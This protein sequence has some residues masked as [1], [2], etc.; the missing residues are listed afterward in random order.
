MNLPKIS[1]ITPSYNQGQYL[2]QTIL[3]VIGQMYPNLE[4]IIMDGGSTDNSVE[5][6]KKYEKHITYWVSKKDKGQAD[7]I[8]RGFER[9]TGDI[10]AWLNSDDYYLPGTLLKIASLLQGRITDPVL[11]HGG[12]IHTHEGKLDVFA[13]ND[14]NVREKLTY[15]DPFVQPTTFWTRGL[16]EKTGPLNK[17]MHYVFDWDWYLRAKQ[18][19]KFIRSE[20]Y[21][22]IYRKHDEH[23][24]GT[25]GVIR[26]NEINGLIKEYCDPEWYSIYL[27][28][29]N[30]DKIISKIHWLKILKVPFLRF[31]LFPHLY[32]KFSKHKLDLFLNV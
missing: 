17:S 9:A 19:A 31:V 26:T 6:I 28:I 14:T 21:F 23:K 27:S 3:S 12:C 20:D 29:N 2:E 25:G 1:I 7:A 11:V 8:N 15:S 24:S 13:R 32:S 30:R 22:C 4:Y 5:I 16:W 18:Y 10:L